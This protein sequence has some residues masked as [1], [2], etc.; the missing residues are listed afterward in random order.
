ME[1]FRAGKRNLVIATDALEEGNN[2]RG[3]VKP[4]KD[5]I[6]FLQDS[7]PY[8]MSGMAQL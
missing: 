6:E 8:Q 4:S 2:D 1:E 3:F 7:G 5:Q